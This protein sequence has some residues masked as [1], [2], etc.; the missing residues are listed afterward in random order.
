MAKKNNN[1]VEQV[2]QL[3]KDLQVVAEK[4]TIKVKKHLENTAK[5]VED[6]IKTNPEKASA[7][8][9]GIGAAL[10]AAAAM[11]LSVDKKPFKKGKKK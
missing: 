11:L 10:G 2:Q 1:M 5:Q 3:G 7:V 9:A 8:A 4:E 6:F